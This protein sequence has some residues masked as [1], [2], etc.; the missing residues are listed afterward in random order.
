MQTIEIYDSSDETLVM[1]YT[2]HFLRSKEIGE[3]F[4][5]GEDAV[6]RRLRRLGVA[7][8][9]VGTK[10]A[11]VHV[12]RNFHV[13]QRGA[14][15]K[16]IITDLLSQGMTKED[17]ARRYLTSA[18][19]VSRRIQEYG[20]NYQGVDKGAPIRAAEKSA[21]EADYLSLTRDQFSAKYGCSRT[22]WLPLLLERGIGRKSEREPD[23]LTLDQKVLVLGSMLGDGSVSKGNTFYEYHCTEQLP[24]LQ[25]KHRMLA[26]VSRDILKV[27]ENGYR[28]ETHPHP[29]FVYLHG[30][31]YVDGVPGKHIPVDLFRK[32]WDDRIL[33][34]WYLDDGHYDSRTDTVSIANKCPDR[35]QLEGLVALM[36][37][38]LHFRFSIK[39]TEQYVK[40]DDGEGTNRLCNVIPSKL[41]HREFF[42]LV[43]RFAPPS[44]LWKVPEEYLPCSASTSLEIGTD[45]LCKY[46][47]LYRARE[48]QSSK[49]DVVSAFASDLIG[50][51]FPFPYQ[52]PARLD[53]YMKGL[54]CATPSFKSKAILSRNGLAI[55]DH[56]FPSQF[57][58]HRKGHPSPLESW[59]S[60][61]FV[62]AVAKDLLENSDASNPQDVLRSVRRL[63]RGAVTVQNPSLASYVY[64]NYNTN[65][66]VLDTSSGYGSRLLAAM[67]LGLSYDGYEP[68]PDTCAQLHNLGTWVQSKIPGGR[69]SIWCA[70]SEV[71]RHKSNKYGLAFTSPPYFDFEVYS[72]DGSQ[73][74]A[75]HPLLADWLTGYWESVL[76]NTSDG[77]VVGGYM[78]VNLSPRS[79]GDI[80]AY[81]G[82]VASR[83]N[84]GVQD[85]LR[86]SYGGKHNGL[87]KEEWLL[88]LRKGYK[89]TGVDL[90]GMVSSFRSEG[91]RRSKP[92]KEALRDRAKAG[93]LDEQSIKEEMRAYAASG[94]NY[95]REHLGEL[96][97]TTG[98]PLSVATWVIEAHFGKWSDFV[99]ECGLAQNYELASLEDQMMDYLLLCA[100]RGGY[101]S[102]YSYGKAKG[103][104]SGDCRFSSRVKR[105]RRS[106][107]GF[108]VLVN[109]LIH[110]G[111]TP[112]SAAKEL[113]ASVRLG[114]SK[115]E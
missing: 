27:A 107:P 46:P 55:L 99:R 4:G 20:I 47:A 83:Y 22:V 106:L 109:K 6:A 53:Y 18:T 74:L 66:F 13:S 104:T 101:V 15:T 35:S 75:K 81:T 1:L 114:S 95:S 24:Y 102:H 98:Y 59:R 49:S 58:A 89:G 100:E 88:V 82:A 68:N 78:V 23:E 110:E 28:F 105:W 96:W 69:F 84:L 86:V 41:Y 56:F 93:G 113:A 92:D 39:G 11:D 73:S 54:L 44:M 26:N 72:G 111:Q 38:R 90:A 77:L 33:A 29:F 61:D 94:G 79:G 12:H 37:E 52:T 85:V 16:E 19:T 3:L 48:D 57:S 80:I 115:G 60:P 76:R 7:K 71:R 21:L 31:F 32:Y 43:C 40:G 30:L 42:E 112:E 14:L 70:G 64:Q 63:C 10:R 34:I 8:R 51:G 17:I 67:S 50:S 45:L 9:P 65:G 36:E 62:H 97:Y 103:E 25:M 2:T 108:E 91:A 87:L 5:V